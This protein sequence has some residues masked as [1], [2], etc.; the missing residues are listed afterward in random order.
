MQFARRQRYQA[1]QAR[2]MMNRAG[3]PAAPPAA[4]QPAMG[5]SA[6]LALGPMPAGPPAAAA[7]PPGRYEVGEAALERH[8]R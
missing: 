5:L 7:V 3:T 4:R 8:A 1:R 6:M 2:R